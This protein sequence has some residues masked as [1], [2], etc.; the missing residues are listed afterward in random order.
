MT[1]VIDIAPVCGMHAYFNTLTDI[2][3]KVIFEFSF[4]LPC[5]KGTEYSHRNHEGNK[6]E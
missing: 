4:S 3:P 5:S 2:G 1:A 6:I